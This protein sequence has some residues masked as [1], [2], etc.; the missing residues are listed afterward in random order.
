[1]KAILEL[2]HN[3]EPLTAQLQK[4]TSIDNA[5][6]IVVEAAKQ[7]GQKFDVSEV[8]GFFA[9]RPK[10]NPE[11]LSEEELEAVSGG[12]MRCSVVL[13]DICCYTCR[14]SEVSW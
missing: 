4:A 3:N 2:L 10:T 13:S 1:V 14:T 12:R 9:Q 6:S 5:A 11:A 8:T 7:R